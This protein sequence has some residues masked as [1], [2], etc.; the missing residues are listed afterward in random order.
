MTELV[1]IIAVGALIAVIGIAF[2]T[3]RGSF[4]IMGYN[5]MSKNNKAKYD[6]VALC[7][8]IGK[9]LLPIGFLTTLFA[10]ESIR[11]WYVWIYLPVVI[12]LVVF[13]TIYINNSS[14]FRN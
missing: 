1:I 6:A 3:G 14:R 11:N 9:I 13:V 10:F 12:G 8:A 5:T 4:L 7:K 2:L